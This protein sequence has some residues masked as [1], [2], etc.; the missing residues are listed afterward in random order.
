MSETNVALH[1][2]VV[3]TSIGLSAPPS[4]AVDGDTLR[5][6]NSGAAPV[7]SITIDLDASYTIVR[8][9][10]VVDQDP[11]GRTTHH[12]NGG[13]DLDNLT[14]LDTIESD[15]TDGQT[16]ERIGPWLG[17]RW[18]QIVTEKSPSWVAWREIRAF[19]F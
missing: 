7:Q 4:A 12:I 6:W 13:S 15:T 11:P 9:E 16:I 17:I 19:S 18:L 8:I 3:A 5:G 1:K 10:L 14:R 2:A